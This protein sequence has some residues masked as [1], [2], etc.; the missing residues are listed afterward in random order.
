MKFIN[1]NKIYT[2]ELEK[3]KNTYQII[4]DDNKRYIIEDVITQPDVISFKL[5]NKIQN[6]CII[7]DKDKTYLAIDGETYT[8]EFEKDISTKSKYGK[9]QK[10][11]SV[12]SPMPGLLVKV[13][14]SVGDQVK[15][16]T[17][18]AIV[19]AMKMQN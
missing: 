13:P 10:G 1:L 18:L 11:N 5:N 14:V 16:G 7:S 4:I 15:S 3:E 17:T 12:S 6:V 19:E 2:V 9:Q 8:L